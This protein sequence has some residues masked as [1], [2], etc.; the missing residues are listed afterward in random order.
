[1]LYPIPILCGRLSRIVPMITARHYTENVHT[2]CD[3]FVASVLPAILHD[4]R[5]KRESRLSTDPEGDFRRGATDCQGGVMDN[6]LVIRAPEDAVAAVPYLVG[7]HPADS[8][9]AVGSVGP[10]WACA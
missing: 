2:D 10:D 7:F 8:L 5:T 1:M 9:V 4:P 3:Y 6:T